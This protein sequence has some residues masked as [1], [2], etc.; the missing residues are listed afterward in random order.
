MAAQRQSALGDYL[1]VT[2][3]D[4]STMPTTDIPSEK[5]RNMIVCWINKQGDD[6]TLDKLLEVMQLIG[7]LGALKSRLAQTVED[8]L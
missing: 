6:A 2:E 1:G 8:V 4:L 7:L 5:I 3:V